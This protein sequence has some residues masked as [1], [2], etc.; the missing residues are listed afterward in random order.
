MTVSVK[1][2]RIINKQF[3]L[4][5]PYS[6]G[7]NLLLRLWNLSVLEYMFSGFGFRFPLPWWGIVLNPSIQILGINQLHF[8]PAQSLIIYNSSLSSSSLSNI[9]I[10][11]LFPIFSNSVFSSQ[12]I[13]LISTEP[14][15][16]SQTNFQFTPSDYSTP[17]PYS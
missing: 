7:T 13:L 8:N 17:K 16:S 4:G 12:T 5:V 1:E 3:F 14:I 9:L 2:I 11:K 15:F 10:P 6:Y